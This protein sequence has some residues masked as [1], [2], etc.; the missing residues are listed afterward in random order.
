M[1]H[2]PEPG[3]TQEDLDELCLDLNQ[4]QKRRHDRLCSMTKIGRMIML[5]FI[6]LKYYLYNLHPHQL[7]SLKYQ[8]FHCQK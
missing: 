4:E 8:Y 3:L 6:F 2:N 5:Y 7:V 1:N